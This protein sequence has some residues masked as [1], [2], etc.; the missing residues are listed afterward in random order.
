MN[1]AAVDVAAEDSLRKL[2]L[3]RP[4]QPPSSLGYVLERCVMRLL[5]SYWRALGN[6]PPSPWSILQGRQFRAV[7]IVLPTLVFMLTLAGAVHLVSY[8]K[9]LK[10]QPANFPGVQ[11]LLVGFVPCLLSS[12]TTIIGDGSLIFK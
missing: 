6:S 4:L 11:A 9:E 10:D 3:P 8:Y 12:V 1:P 2:V 7:L 5:S